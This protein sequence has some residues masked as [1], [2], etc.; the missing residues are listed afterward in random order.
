[1]KITL[2]EGDNVDL[3]REPTPAALAPLNDDRVLLDS[4]KKELD[5]RGF[6]ASVEFPGCIHIIER[7][8]VLGTANVSWGADLCNA[9]GDQIAS[10][11]LPR[12]SSTWTDAV[13]IVDAFIKARDEFRDRQ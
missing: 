6:A 3:I 12:A 11:D 7:T 4:I 8:W 2:Q 9:R 5:R 1:M 10:I 13:Q